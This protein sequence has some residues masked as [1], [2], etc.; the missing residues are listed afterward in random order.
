MKAIIFTPLILG[1]IPMVDAVPIQ[2]IALDGFI[3]D[4]AA[5]K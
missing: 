2:T 4:S 3:I 5:S 1:A